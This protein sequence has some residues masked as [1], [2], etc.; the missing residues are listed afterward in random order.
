MFAKGTSFISGPVK[1]KSNFNVVF[2]SSE[3]I[4]DAA[5]P[6]PLQKN[7]LQPLSGVSTDIKGPFQALANLPF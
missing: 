1:T 7:L 5:K 3:D 6:R 2:L 4:S